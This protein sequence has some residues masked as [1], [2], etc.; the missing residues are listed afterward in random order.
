MVKEFVSA[1]G[2]QSIVVI[3]DVF[4]NKKTFSTNYEVRSHNGNNLCKDNIFSLIKTFQD[5]GVGEIV[6]NSIDRDGSKIRCKCER[7]GWRKLRSSW[8]DSPWYYASTNGLRF[9]I[10]ANS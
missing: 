4:K 6:I 7:P 1:V 3:L 8:C 5:L 9:R 10:E 2:G